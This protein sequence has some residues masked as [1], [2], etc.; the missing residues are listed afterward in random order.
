MGSE[1]LDQQILDTQCGDSDWSAA[2]ADAVEPQAWPDEETA[3]RELLAH[4]AE[5]LK[6]R[7]KR[8][9]MDSHIS[10]GSFALS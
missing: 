1:S 6:Y 4:E 5:H 8:A 7:V 10:L 9:K 3:L 2:L